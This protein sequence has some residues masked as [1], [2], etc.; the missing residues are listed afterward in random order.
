MKITRKFI[1]DKAS[2]SPTTVSNV[3]NNDPGARIG[4][5]TRKRVIKIAKKYNYFPNILARSLVM[6]KTFNIG[7]ISTIPIISFLKYPFNNAIFFGLETEIENNGF[8][9]VFSLLKSADDINFSVRKM[10]LGNIVDGIILYGRVNIQLINLL[11]TNNTKFVLIDYYL[12]DI[13]TNSVLPENAQGAYKATKYL[14]EKK[15]QKIYCLNGNENHPSY[16]ERPDGYKK[17]MLENNLKPVI[18]STTPTIE[19]TYFYI[20]ELIKKKNLPDAFFAAGDPMAMGTLRALKDSGYKVPEQ[21]K[22]IGFDNIS[23]SEM[24]TPQLTTVNVPQIEMGKEAV[25]LLLEKIEKKDK[26]SLIRLPTEL[27]IRDSA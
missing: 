14:I 10:I 13:Q 7:F 1:A 24:E 6:Q 4:E 18:L 25:K 17:A 9:L 27:I 26:P 12:D 2:V 8:S 5:E 3:L 16:K 21:I 23:L 11:K 19:D 22:V 15:C 20:L